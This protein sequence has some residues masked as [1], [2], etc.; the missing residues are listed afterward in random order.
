MAEDR[1][2]RASGVN[3]AELLERM[4]DAFLGLGPDGE[5]TYLNERARS[6]IA[7][8]FD[9]P[10][11]GFDL[12][13][14]S[15]WSELPQARET[16][17][18]DYFH[19]AMREQREFS[20]EAYYGPLDQWFQ[21]RVYPSETGVSVFFKD[22]TEQRQRR[23]RLERQEQ[24]LREMYE[25]VSR[26][27]LS[28]EDRV[29]D[30][31]DTGRDVLGVE[32]ATLSHVEEDEYV[33]EVVRSPPDTIEAGDTIDLAET[34]C[35]RVVMETEPLNVGDVT[36]DAPELTD[37]EGFTELGISCYLGAPISVGGDTYGTLCFYDTD[38]RDEQFSDWERTLV[39]LMSRWVGTALDRTQTAAKL[40]RQNER[41]DGFAELLSHD[42]RNPLQVAQANLELAERDDTLDPLDDAQS[43]IWR[44][45]RM[46]S[47]MLAM[48]RGGRE[49]EDHQL[50]PVSLETVARDAWGAVASETATLSVELDETTDA[51]ATDERASIEADRDRLLRVFENLARN[52]VDHAG[53]DVTVRVGTTPEGFY[54]ADDGPGIPTGRREDVFEHGYTTAQKGTGFGLSIVA[55]IAGAHDWTVELTE[56]ADGG[57]RVDFSD[58]G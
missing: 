14:T 43:A 57:A 44:I 25:T 1:P 15:L 8:A 58:V 30:L 51:A 12:V 31:L 27:E 13:G 16:E 46:V 23:D 48:A 9:D 3:P 49:V 10:E 20:Y 19:K 38:P 26:T 47:D 4:T 35:E 5:V 33:F 39:E 29:G 2:S 41:L 21:V 24:A 53:P 18:H 42:L 11:D 55:E 40:R 34:N 56:S 52:A 32:Y 28:F 54:V 45:D 50:E 17:L 7:P 37:R 22:V 6:L 36:V